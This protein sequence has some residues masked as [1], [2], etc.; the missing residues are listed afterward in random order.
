MIMQEGETTLAINTISDIIRKIPDKTILISQE[1]GS[2]EVL[3][4][5]NS[6]K[7]KL[8]TIDVDNFPTIQHINPNATAI[9]NAKD[10]SKIIQNTSFA[11]STDETRY[12]LNGIYLNINNTKITSAATDGHRLS[13]SSIDLSDN[14]NDE[15]GVILPS[16]TVA[17][18]QK[19]LKDT[20]VIET[21]INISLETNK[22]AFHN[23]N[24][25]LVS[26]LID[27]QF[28]DYDNFFPDLEEDHYIMN[29]NTELL[30]E[31]IDRVATITLEKF[32]A[33][34]LK[35]SP[36][37]LDILATGEAKGFGHEV[38][39]QSTDS[40]KYFD[41]T[42]KEMEVGFNPQYIIDILR[43]VTS[44]KVQLYFY[45]FRS[46]LLITAND[47]EDSRFVIMPYK[48]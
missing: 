4:K 36:G 6:C 17:E 29:V 7:F 26:K 19:I 13:T 5:A 12:N 47:K 48:V 44:S 10:L 18:L 21:D 1:K 34:K 32:K 22:I 35:L 30:K 24:F 3:I 46:P 14:K 25:T 16:K 23:N 11:M 27:G 41:Y 28:P 15:F 2:N 43:N 40:K 39:E 8:V 9:L 38:L 31:A 42:G 45:D 33:V 20:N 37:R